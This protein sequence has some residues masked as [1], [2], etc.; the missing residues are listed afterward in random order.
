[1]LD[2]SYPE[3]TFVGFAHSSKGTRASTGFLETCGK[4]FSDPNNAG[5]DLAEL[6]Q[7][8]GKTCSTD[9]IKIYQAGTTDGKK[10]VLTQGSNPVSMSHFQESRSMK[11]KLEA[12]DIEDWGVLKTPRAACQDESG[13]RKS[14]GWVRL[15]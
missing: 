14:L 9:T 10:I 8:V 12:I 1:M 4:T 3:N 2:V 5:K 7:V 11:R 15:G 6:F 13:L